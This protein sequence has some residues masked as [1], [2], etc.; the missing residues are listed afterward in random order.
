MALGLDLQ[1]VGG[2]WPETKHTLDQS[3]PGD[4]P[5]TIS[6]AVRIRFRRLSAHAQAVLSAASVLGDRVE[7][8][9]L[10]RKTKLP[11]ETV[12]PTLDE[13][14]RE[15]WLVAEGRGYGFRARVIRQVVARDMVLPGQR[16]RLQQET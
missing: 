15:G 11:M 12:T 16:Q 4:L 3:L 2:A 7:P 10:A 6:S 13:L 9:L 1:M 5:D 8:G 14:E